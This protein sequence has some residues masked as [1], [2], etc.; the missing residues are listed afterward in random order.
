MSLAALIEHFQLCDNIIQ[1]HLNALP[2][3]P[4]GRQAGKLCVASCT[5][6]VIRFVHPKCVWLMAVQATIWIYNQKFSVPSTA[7]MSKVFITTTGGC[8]HSL[9]FS[10]ALSLFFGFLLLNVTQ[11]RVQNVAHISWFMTSNK[12]AKMH[13]SFVHLLHIRREMIRAKKKDKNDTLFTNWPLLCG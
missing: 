9:P 3:T 10:L 8:F 11:S 4:S 5:V 7:P 6:Y 12:I 2:D 13:F 1:V